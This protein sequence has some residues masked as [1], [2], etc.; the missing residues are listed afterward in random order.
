MNIEYHKWYSHSLTQEMAI[1]VYGHSGKPLLVFPA[2]AGTFF[3]FE[4]FGMIDAIREFIESGKVQVFTVDSIDAQSWANWI[5]HPADR[6]QR[7]NDYDRYI[8]NEVSPFIFNKN[9][10]GKKL[11]ATGCSMGGC[12]AGN[13]FFRHPDIFDTVIA[14]SG[15]FQMTLF[16]GDYSDENIYLNSPIHYLPNLEDPWYL[17]KYRESQII[18]C[19]GQGAWEEDMM[20][21]AQQM[22]S[23]LENKQIPAWVDFWGYDV[24]HDWP[25]WRQQLPYFLGHI[26]L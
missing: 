5:A 3:E 13:F 22:K 6:A 18:I 1:K 2:Q 16:V 4:D 7:H 25:W 11:I 10:T 8:V 9:G 15:L 20:R 26:E 24:N 23:I 14:L 17:D 21:D 19:T 12:H